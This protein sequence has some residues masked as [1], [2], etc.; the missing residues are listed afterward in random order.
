MLTDKRLEYLTDGK[1]TA[2]ITDVEIHAI[3]R[4]IVNLRKLQK[5]IP[6]CEIP[7]NHTVQCVVKT[8]FDNVYAIQVWDSCNKTWIGDDYSYDADEV[9]H[10]LPLP[11]A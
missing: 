2:D 8:I 5:W 1:V 4:E 3:C 10:Y 6:V 9:T 11:S 7:P